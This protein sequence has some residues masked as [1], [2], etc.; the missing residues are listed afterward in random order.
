MIS[1]E[2]PFIEGGTQ[3]AGTEVV[4]SLAL[5]NGQNSIGISVLLDAVAFG[6]N[7]DLSRLRDVANGNLFLQAAE[8]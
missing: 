2:P 5:C 8:L 6:C 3:G 1:S 7:P 4:V